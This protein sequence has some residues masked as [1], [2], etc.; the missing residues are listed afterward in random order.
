MHALYR[1]FRSRG[2]VHHAPLHVYCVFYH[3]LTRFTAKII[4]FSMFICYFLLD[5]SSLK[6][7]NDLFEK[8]FDQRPTSLSSSFL[9]V[10]LLKV[11]LHY[12]SIEKFIL[13]DSF[14]CKGSHN[15]K[16]EVSDLYSK[17]KHDSHD[18]PMEELVFIFHRIS[19]ERRIKVSYHANRTRFLSVT[20]LSASIVKRPLDVFHQ[21]F[22][23][24]FLSSN[25]FVDRHRQVRTFQ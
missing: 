9:Q 5:R 24:S 23:F 12:Y 20:S 16:I 18:T 8:I 7:G 2:A 11:E 15:N 10:F 22:S 6:R 1:N 4:S 13:R 25:S 14:H 3:F 17:T 21:L 19:F